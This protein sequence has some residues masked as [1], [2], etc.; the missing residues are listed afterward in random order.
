M[1]ANGS[2]YHFKAVG[3]LRGEVRFNEQQWGESQLVLGGKPYRLGFKSPGVAVA[4]GKEL[5]KS[6]GNR[7]RLMVYPRTAFPTDRRQ[8]HAICWVAVAFGEELPGDLADGEFIIS[9]AYQKLPCY[10]YPLVSVYRNRRDDYIEALKGLDDLGKSRFLRPAHLPLVWTD[11]PV[12]AATFNPKSKE[13]RPVPFVSVVAK[14]LIKS[15]I[16]GHQETLKVEPDL[17]PHLKVPKAVR[18][19]LAVEFAARAK[20]AKQAKQAG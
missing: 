5:A 2:N 9:G 11:P 13:Q 16:F 17:P 12:R 1:S 18:A 19:R 4:L 10:G 7:C 14:F 3:V 8:S 6:R 15:D 20:Q